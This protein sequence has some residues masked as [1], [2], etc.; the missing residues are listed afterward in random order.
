LVLDLS[1]KKAMRQLLGKRLDFQV[2]RGKESDT[3]EE[4]R[5]CHAL[6][7]EKP[8]SHVRAQEE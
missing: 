2:P 3:R 8:S 6:E 5:L 1:V 7:K 4:M